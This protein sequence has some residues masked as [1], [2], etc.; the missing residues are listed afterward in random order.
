MTIEHDESSDGAGHSGER[1][2]DIVST[3]LFDAPPARVFDAWTIPE[4]LIRWWAPAG[5]STPVC[6]VNLRPGGVFHYCMRLPDERDIWGMGT[7]REIAAPNRLV[8]VDSFADSGGRPVPPSH[9]GMSAEHPAETLV[10]VTF[11]AWAQGT[12]LTLRHG[13]PEA[14]QEH[15]ASAQGWT[16]MLD[17]LAGVLADADA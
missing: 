12:K 4:L 8:Y 7:Y 14:V 11:E 2:H 16:E 6:R 17:R 15:E 13:I 3:R 10:T 1:L 9:Y 5:C